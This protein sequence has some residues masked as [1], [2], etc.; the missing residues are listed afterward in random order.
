MINRGTRR[1]VPT[2]SIKSL[3]LLTRTELVVYLM[4]FSAVPLAFLA[5]LGVAIHDGDRRPRIWLACVFLL[6]IVGVIVRQYAGELLR[7]RRAESWEERER[8]RW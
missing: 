1:R 2:N 3:R 6:A 4:L 5:A 8:R 7:R